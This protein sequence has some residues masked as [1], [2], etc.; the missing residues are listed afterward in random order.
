MHQ[1]Y[2]ENNLVGSL[3]VKNAM[4]L[5]AKGGVGGKGNKYFASPQWVFNILVF[6]RWRI[7]AVLW[8]IISIII[9]IL[10][11]IE[12]AITML[13][14][15]YKLNTYKLFNN[16]KQLYSTTSV[17]YFS[18]TVNQFVTDI[19][20]L[21]TTRLLNTNIVRCLVAIVLSQ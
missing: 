21:K 7:R 3:D 20:T 10:H 12:L 5:A 17:Q 1:I 19:S 11:T 15:K 4:F 9:I 2:H 16:Y 14:K 8:R 18:I 13:Q 6:L